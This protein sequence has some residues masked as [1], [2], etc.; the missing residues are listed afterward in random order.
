V[1]IE[2]Q[3]EEASDA[4]QRQKAA[5]QRQPRSHISSLARGPQH[6]EGADEILILQHN[7]TKMV[8]S[9]QFDY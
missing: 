4:E 8:L 7:K 9:N 2:H 3:E 6:D 1:D 5:P